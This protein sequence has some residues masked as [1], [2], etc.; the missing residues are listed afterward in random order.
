M[1]ALIA[2]HGLCAGYGG[3]PVVSDLELEIGAGEVVA[4]LASN[5]A[6]KTTTLMTLAG[7]LPPMKGTV[8]WK[9]VSTRAPL[10]RR[11]RQGLS[12]I[13]EQRWVFMGL[14]TADNLRLGRGGIEKAL[15]LFP[16]LRP[17]LR[18]KVGLLSGG[19]Q[20]LLALARALA[21]G[22]ELLLADELSLG[23]APIVVHRLLGAVREAANRGVG[24]LLVEQHVRQAL[25]VADR[26]YILHRGRIAMSG[27]AGDLLRRIDE[28]ERLYLTGGV[29]RPTVVQ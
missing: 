7:D 21:S 9:G 8:T 6:G 16:E 26:A 28:I 20:Q 1:T 19:Q 15:A 12:L 4:L 18:R 14:S 23:L 27:N 11:A 2:A 3:V 5:G 13:S 22:P 29:D 17:H 25:A 10:H 24:V